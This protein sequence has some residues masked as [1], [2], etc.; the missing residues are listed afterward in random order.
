MI[1][2]KQKSWFRA[3]KDIKF[4]NSFKFWF[5]LMWQNGYIQIFITAFIVTIIGLFKLD[6]IIKT[7]KDNYLI[8][9]LFGGAA[10][11]IGFSIPLLICLIVAYKGFWQYFNRLKKE[12]NK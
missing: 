4:E 10:T 8:D 3:D 12:A 7:V 11:T 6:F 2:K 5:A 9:G 1:D